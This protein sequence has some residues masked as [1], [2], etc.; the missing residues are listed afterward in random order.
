MVFLGRTRHG[1]FMAER[2]GQLSAPTKNTPV[3]RIQPRELGV[4]VC[5]CG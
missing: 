4:Q 1:L 2:L 3:D 5:R